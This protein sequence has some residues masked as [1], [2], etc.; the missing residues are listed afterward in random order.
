MAIRTSASTP[1]VEGLKQELAKL[2]T[3]VDLPDGDDAMKDA[4]FFGQVRF[5]LDIPQGFSHAYMKGDILPL[6]AFK[7]PDERSSLYL[8]MAIDQYF[9]LAGLYRNTLPQIGEEQLVK[10]VANNLEH[11]SQ[12]IFQAGATSVRSIPYAKVYFNFMSYSLFN[13]LILGICTLMLVF[14][15]REIRLRNSCSPISLR[16]LNG[17]LF[18]AGLVYSLICWAIMTVLCLLIQ[19]DPLPTINLFFFLLNGLV[20]TVWAASAAFAIGQLTENRNAVSN[21]AT[22]ITLLSSFLGG[23]FVPQEFLGSGLLQFAQ[24]L[25][26]YW[27]VRANSQIAGIGSIG[28]S[29][30]LPLLGSLAMQL[31]FALAFISVALVISRKKRQMV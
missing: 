2:A 30:S 5:V 25:P 4:L 10:S 11:K 21:M 15:Q 9:R 28:I 24:Y 8:K 27:Y 31:L 19:S 17:Q 20:F 29:E 6:V 3:I 1:L 12:V 14:N 22:V 23:A 13:L 26:T 18:L 7:R 16:K